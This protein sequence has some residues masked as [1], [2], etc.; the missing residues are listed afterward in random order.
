MA[1]TRLENLG[2]ETSSEPQLGQVITWGIL[3]IKCNYCGAI[4]Q[5]DF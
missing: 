3:L 2:L 4:G 1:K 5:D